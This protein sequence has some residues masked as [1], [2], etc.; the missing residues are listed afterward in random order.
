[1]L[2][3]DLEIEEVE[4]KFCEVF[5]KNKFINTSIKK[6]GFIGKFLIKSF[7]NESVYYSKNCN[8]YCFKNYHEPKSITEKNMFSYMTKL[9]SNNGLL[10]VPNL[11]INSYPG[12]M[13][14]T[15]AY[16]HYVDEKIWKILIQVINND[17]LA[18]MNFDY[19]NKFMISIYGEGKIKNNL[20]NIFYWEDNE[21]YI[22]SELS[23]SRKNTFFHWMIKNEFSN[24]WPEIM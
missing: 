13:F 2:I 16:L 23:I 21:S 1:M 19:F 3:L 11:D 22:V 8:I 20:K 14:G 15:T 5:D 24:N 10:I 18:P 4:F 17:V 7:K 6:I 9:L 12:T